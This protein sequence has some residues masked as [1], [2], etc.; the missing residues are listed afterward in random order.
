VVPSA[1]ESPYMAPAFDRILT[2]RRLKLRQFNGPF[3]FSAKCNLG[4]EGAAG[5]ILLFLN[6]DIVPVTQ[7]W[8]M[9]LL[10]PFS[11]PGIAV[12]G[13]LLVYP[14]AQVQHCGLYVGANGVTG[15][16]LRFARLPEHDYMFLG[17]VPRNVSVVT[18][19][20][21]AIRQDVFRSVNGFDEQLANYIQDV[22]LCLRVLYSGHA[23][24]LNPRSI[25]I[26]A[27]TTTLKE[28]INHTLVIQARGREFE[29]FMR[30][31]R[32]HLDGGD[33]YHNPRMLM[34]DESLRTLVFHPISA[35]NG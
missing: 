7:D 27:E 24:V 34:S 14:N 22:D 5:D 17:S 33:P 31:W 12:A 2:D 10:A 15:H 8:L 16:A 26:H 23:V 25:L 21:L 18:G 20:A 6:D 30:R 29:Y 28:D 13:P 4:A 11:N 1:P 35:G 9:E 3:N 19:A 32:A